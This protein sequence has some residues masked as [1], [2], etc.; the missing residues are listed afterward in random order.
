MPQGS[1]TYDYS[2]IKMVNDRTKFNSNDHLFVIS[3]KHIYDL[4]SEYNNV[5]YELNIFSDKNKLNSYFNQA[6]VVFL[7]SNTMSIRNLLKLNKN[8]LNRLK[9]SKINNDSSSLGGIVII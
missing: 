3:S 2:I 7:H 8:P 4:C 1:K 5:V 6:L 9:Y